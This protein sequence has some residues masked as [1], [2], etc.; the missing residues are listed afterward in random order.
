MYELTAIFFVLF[1]VA[2]TTVFVVSNAVL[3]W[4]GK[5]V[6]EI[7]ILQ[8]IPMILLKDRIPGTA[9]YFAICFAITLVLSVIFKKTEEF[10]A[11][12]KS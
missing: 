3:S 12:H 1:I 4:L 7:Y 10:Y 9:L 8:R 6:F 5:F 11:V 2:L